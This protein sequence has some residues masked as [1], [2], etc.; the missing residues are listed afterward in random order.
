MEE[1]LTPTE[2]E[3]ERVVLHRGP[4]S[5]LP[6]FAAV[7]STRLG[8]AVG[9]TRMW[10]YPDWR[11]GLA[12][13]LRLSA[14]MSLKN[15][16]AGLDHGGGKAVIA[17]P[18]DAPLSRAEREAAMRD[19]GDLVDSL[20]GAL[21]VGE[22]VGTTAEDMLV[23]SGGTRWV[24]GLP[25]SAGGSGEPAEPTA[26]GVYASI[27]SSARH[28]FGTDDLDGRSACVIGL[29][30]VGERLVRRLASD[31]VRLTVTD[32]DD[33]KR[34]LAE[35]LG[36][37][38][39]ATDEAAYVEAD[40]LVPAALGGLLTPA[41]VPLLRCKAVVGP[42]NNQ[43]SDDAVATLLVERGILWAPDF[44]VN[45]GGVVY[46]VAVSLHGSSRPDALAAVDAIG[47][48][49]ASVFERAGERGVPPLTVAL[50]DARARIAA[51]GA[52]A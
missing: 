36:A 42:A 23:V 46:G 14:A 45:A 13:V 39:V 19:L 16:A 8:A 26:I 52:A 22:D 34:A 21:I 5:G 17:L 30:Q 25:A 41:S 32:V 29:G 7:H 9:G 49:L 4:R 11:D 44:I 43:L 20:G 31:G 10:A 1:L 18:S 35:E 48:R 37:A 12:D 15:A 38:W 2:F 6:I 27:R 40:L 33:A 3:H 51:E 50:D 28:L 24:G 47:E